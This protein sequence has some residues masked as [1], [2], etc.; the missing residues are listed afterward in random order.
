MKRSI[1]LIGLVYGAVIAISAAVFDRVTLGVVVVA[2][3]IVTVFGLAPVLFGILTRRNEREKIDPA[4]AEVISLSD[5]EGSDRTSKEVD[6]SALTGDDPAT[7][8]SGAFPT[9]IL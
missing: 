3:V 2:M 9:P 8:R 7:P 4:H 6:R 5:L 1:L